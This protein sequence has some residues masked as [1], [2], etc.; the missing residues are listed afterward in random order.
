MPAASTCKPADE[1]RDRWGRPPR[2]PISLR[3]ACWRVLLVCEVHLSDR[4]AGGALDPYA[5]HAPGARYAAPGASAGSMV[6]PGRRGAVG[7]PEWP[8]AALRGRC[9]TLASGCSK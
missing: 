7:S 4:G 3:N 8:C 1:Q 6:P 9:T 2:S 5:Q